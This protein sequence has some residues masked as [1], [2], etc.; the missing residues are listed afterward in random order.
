MSKES[1]REFTAK[2]IGRKNKAYEKIASSKNIVKEKTKKYKF[3]EGSKKVARSI[4][5]GLGKL[6]ERSKEREMRERA[7]YSKKSKSSK[8]GR[9]V[10]RAVKKEG[11]RGPFSYEDEAGP[12]AYKSVDYG[13]GEVFAGKGKNKGGP[14]L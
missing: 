4:S 12:F 14:F 1:L 7:Y 5:K 8:Y 13:T 3:K 10:L 9:K 2:R 11:M 6:R